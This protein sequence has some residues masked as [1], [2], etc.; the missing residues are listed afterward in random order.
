MRVSVL[1]A[2]VGILIAAGMLAACDSNP[3]EPTA[4][5]TPQPRDITVSGSG[6]VY[7]TPDIAT[8]SIGVHTEDES[9]AR[10][11]SGNNAQVEKVTEVLMEMGVDEKDIQTSNFNIFL[12]QRYDDD[13]NPS[14][15][16]YIVDNTVFVTVRNLDLLGEIMGAVVAAGANSIFGIQFDTENKTQALS[17]AR[18]AAVE[19]AQK[20]AEELAQAAGVTLGEIQSINETGGVPVPVFEGKSGGGLGA[21]NDQVPAS[22]GQLSLTVEVSVVYNIR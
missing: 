21:M 6:K 15:T 14:G 20:K 18:K 4:T 1:A 22:L 13:G 7:L 19:N 2:I 17:E 16:M 11:V 10:A 3:G 12:E 8:I 9:A 5:S